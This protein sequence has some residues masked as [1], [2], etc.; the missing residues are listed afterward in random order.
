MLQISF[1][2]FELADLEREL[3]AR[4]AAM[5]ADLARPIGKAIKFKYSILFVC[6]KRVCNGA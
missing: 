3:A 6:V 4:K 2:G 1:S 5:H